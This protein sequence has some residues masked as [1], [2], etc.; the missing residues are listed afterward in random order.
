VIA[1][2]KRRS[3]DEGDEILFFTLQGKQVDIP[4]SRKLGEIG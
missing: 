2:L 3:G 4:K 1:G